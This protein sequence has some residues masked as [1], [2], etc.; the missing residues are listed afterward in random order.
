MSKRKIQT[1]EIIV[2]IEKF[3]ATTGNDDPQLQM[4]YSG[5]TEASG[6]YGIS[7]GS[8][9]SAGAQ[10]FQ[11]TS[12]G[13]AFNFWS[14]TGVAQYSTMLSLTF[15][16]VGGSSIEAHF[17]GTGFTGNNAEVYTTGGTASVSRAYTGFLLKSSSSNVSGTA[18][19]YGL[20]IV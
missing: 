12:N 14:T 6:Y 3:S 11:A 7:T 17:A 15:T 1:D 10:L 4:I 9:F 5:T 2:V 18:S 20:A 16:R 13:A 8:G 19:I